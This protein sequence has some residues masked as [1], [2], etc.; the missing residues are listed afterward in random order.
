MYN[1]FC[2]Y[3]FPIYCPAWLQFGITEFHKMLLHLFGFREKRNVKSRSCLIGIIET[4]LRVCRESAWRLDGKERLLE[5][6]ALRQ[7]AV[8]VAVAGVLQGKTRC[9]VSV[10]VALYRSLEV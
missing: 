2:P 5:V 10:S 7:P 8:S 1:N 4:N 6:C 3:Y 9:C